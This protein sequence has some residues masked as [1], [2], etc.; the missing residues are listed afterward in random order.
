MLDKL[1]RLEALHYLNSVDEWNALRA[2]RNTF[3]HD[4]P[5]E[6]TLKAA[7]LNEAVTSVK[8]F[9]ALLNRISPVVERIRH[10]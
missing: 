4:S 1:Y 3:S 6:Y 8:I 10:G 9:E 7:Y 5:Q 2:I